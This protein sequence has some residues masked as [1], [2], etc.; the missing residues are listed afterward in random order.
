VSISSREGPLGTGLSIHGRADGGVAVDCRATKISSAVCGV[1]GTAPLVDP[2]RLVAGRVRLRTRVDIAARGDFCHRHVGGFPASPSRT[3]PIG[4]LAPTHAPDAR[5]ASCDRQ[6]AHAALSGHTRQQ[7]Y[8]TGRG[9][10]DCP[11]HARQ[12][13]APVG[14]RGGRPAC[15]RGREHQRCL[16]QRGAACLHRSSNLHG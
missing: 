2:A 12:L 10:S 8:S 4:W 9:H 1:R 15:Q 5:I 3:S 11:H 13:T 14:I 16:R 7:W 6:R